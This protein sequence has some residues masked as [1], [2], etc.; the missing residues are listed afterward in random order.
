[1]Y[2][3][4]FSPASPYVRKVLLSAYKAGIRNQIELISPDNHYENELL[5]GQN[6][7]GKIPVLQKPDGG[8]LFDSRVIIDHFNRIGGGLIP[9]EGKER[10]IILTRSAIAEGLIDA[11]LLIVYSDRYA[12]GQ[13]PSKVW[14]DLQIGKIERTLDYLEKDIINWSSPTG[15]DAANIGLGAALGYMSFRNVR[16]WEDNRPKL[17]EWFK[18][19]AHNLP[20][21]LET[22]P[23]N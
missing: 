16:V 17:K 13:V 19:K 11:S 6:S 5:R 4:T 20:G 18:D 7:L 14:L 21:F 15:F 12:G 10:D 3:L 1:M 8:Y 2:K 23:V 9:L 22:V